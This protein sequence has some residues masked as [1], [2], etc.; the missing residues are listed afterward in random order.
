MTTKRLSILRGI[1]LKRAL[2][3]AT[4]IIGLIDKNPFSPTYGCFD[5]DFWHYKIKDYPSGTSQLGS[6]YITLL[7]LC[8]HK[9][10]IFYKN[11]NMKNWA[12]AAMKFAA[13]FSHKDGSCDDYYPFEKALGAT[14]FSL[15]GCTE[16]YILLN[17]KNKRLEGFFEKRAM[18]I[19]KH[20]EPGK[21]ANHLI[22][23][24]LSLLNVFII[25]KKN[26]YL[27]SSRK[28]I[29]KALKWMNDEGWFCEYNGCDPGYHTLSIN[30]LAEY[31]KKIGDKTLL[32]YLKKMVEFA[33]Y[34]IH[35]DGSYG[36]I[37][38]SRNTSHFL[39]HGFELIGSKLP[40]AT[41]VTD[42]Y[43]KG[44]KKK[45]DE[46]MNDDKY[47]IFS[48]DKL[49]SFLDFNFKRKNKLKR[50]DFNK[51]FKEAKFFI[52]KKNDFYYVINC[53]KGG[54][55]KIFK[56]DKLI[57]CDSGIIT[58]MSKNILAVS[59]I[60]DK[61]KI[62]INKDNIKI[63]GKLNIINNILMD[64]RKFIIFRIVLLMFGR[65]NLIST[66]IKKFLTKLTILYKKGIGVYFKREFLFDEYDQ[67]TIIDEIYNHSNQALK[68]KKL[69][70]GNTNT[71]IYIPTS[72]YFQE[73]DLMKQTNLNDKIHELNKNAYIIIKRKIN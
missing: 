62:E 50:N 71:S 73:A 22:V 64:T 66:F 20:N 3:D 9:D 32:K 15:Y 41:Q 68:F 30:F 24:A 51:Y 67:C 19:I 48:Y 35:P 8:K 57:L 63:T 2:E 27:L 12:I 7:Y 42:L 46:F 69:C 31:Y 56:K 54:Q 4:K 28:K 33:S 34:F 6:L 61:K 38:G 26:K 13:K 44:I 55:V 16:S 58:L 40:L 59:H 43:L 65:Y 1:Y 52:K 18:W 23:A 39:S 10:N 53:I 60:L 29:K 36:G 70:F 72:R 37:Y 21:I 47:V 11:E 14:S 17:E 49:Y 5:R 25:T 45:K